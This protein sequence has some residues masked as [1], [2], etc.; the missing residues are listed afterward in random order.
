M[1]WHKTVRDVLAQTP[2]RLHAN[3][4]RCGGP[5]LVGPTLAALL[6]LE[7]AFFGHIRGAFTGAPQETVGNVVAALGPYSL[8]P[9]QQYLAAG[10]PVERRQP[11]RGQVGLR[12][13][14]LLLAPQG[15]RGRCLPHLDASGTQCKAESRTRPST[16]SAPGRSSSPGWRR[17]KIFD[18]FFPVTTLSLG[19]VCSCPETAACAKTP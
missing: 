9:G 19:R 18:P 1:Y 6:Y 16:G 13:P 5:K 10:L 14:G 8:S 3:L 12:R 7:R 17:P 15:K 4:R 11:R 2:L